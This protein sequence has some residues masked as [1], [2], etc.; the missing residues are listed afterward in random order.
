M[1]PDQMDATARLQ[2][3]L[4]MTVFEAELL[5]DEVKSLK[6]RITEATDEIA[7]LKATT[8]S[9]QNGLSKRAASR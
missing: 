8:P 3:L 7:A 6:K 1:P 4:G 9:P 2:Y 5:K